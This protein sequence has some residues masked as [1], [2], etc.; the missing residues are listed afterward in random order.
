MPNTSFQRSWALEGGVKELIVHIPRNSWVPYTVQFIGLLGFIGLLYKF[1][2]YAIL[3]C[4]SSVKKKKKI[5][6]KIDTEYRPP[7]FIQ[8]ISY[9]R[10]FW[11]QFSKIPPP[12]PPQLFHLLVNGF[13]CFPDVLP[14]HLGTYA[15]SALKVIYFTPK[16]TVQID[17]DSDFQPGRSWFESGPRQ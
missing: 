9:F 10:R 13:L 1:V 17:E 2:S 12:P 11:S 3:A 16:Q 4:N 7:K 8:A 14:W 6:W 15:N 5:T